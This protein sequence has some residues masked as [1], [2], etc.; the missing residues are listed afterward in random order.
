MKH[1]LT[2]GFTLVELVVVIMILGILASVAVPRFLDLSNDASQAALQHNLAVIR[3]AIETYAARNGGDLP[4]AGDDLPTDL[5]PLLRGDFP[6]CPVGIQNASI[7]YVT[8]STPPTGDQTEN[9]GWK[10]N[11]TTGEFICN[12]EDFDDF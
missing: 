6:E 1:R 5:Q 2:R 9:T 10:F 12:H 7:T 8:G 3:D 4:G 11:K